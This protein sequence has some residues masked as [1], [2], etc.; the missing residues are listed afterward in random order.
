[1][2]SANAI[3]LKT[4][5]A[6]THE[7]LAY[8]ASDA[9]VQAWNEPAATLTGIPI[10]RALGSD[11]R[12]LLPGGVA[13]VNVPFDGRS[14]DLQLAGTGADET[15]LRLRVAAVDLDAQTHGWLCSF[16]F[17]RR[18]REIE[19]LKNEIVASVSDELKTPIATIKAYAETLRENPTVLAT[20]FDEFLRIIDEQADRLARCIDDLLLAS[21]VDAEQLLRRRVET[22]LDDLLETVVTTLA[23]DAVAHPLERATDGISLSGDPDLLVE[24]L[25]HALDNAAK[26]SPPGAPIRVEGALRDNR[27]VV[28]IVDRGIGIPDEHLPYV[29]DRFYRIENTSTASVGGAGLGLFIVAALMRAHGGQVTIESTLGSGSVVKLAFP[30]RDA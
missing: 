9:L 3:P 21:R 18:H 29:F 22:R 17:E 28:A 27:V 10:E 12:T 5:F 15:M 4:L 7:G 20:Q 19:Q 11:I 1:M 24:I 13:I 16:G 30:V 6:L 8:V 2:G 14:H 23:Y 25:R 26:Y